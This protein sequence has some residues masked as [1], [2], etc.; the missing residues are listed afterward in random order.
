MS[1][2][3][4]LEEDAVIRPSQRKEAFVSDNCKLPPLLTVKEAALK[5][6][7][8][9]ATIRAWILRREKLEVVRIGRCVRIT[10]RSIAKLIEDNTIK[11]KAY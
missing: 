4:G 6:H 9:V 8:K 1:H 5:L 11:P 2:H 10:E 7:V 3:G